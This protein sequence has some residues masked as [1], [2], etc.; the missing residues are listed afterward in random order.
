MKSR[1]LLAL[2]LVAGL[3]RVLPAQV[4]V[5][6]DAFT[7]SAL[8]NANYGVSL[9]LV[10]QSPTAT[11]TMV[12]PAEFSGF[13]ANTYLKFDLAA[14]PS[15]AVPGN[16]AKANLRLYVDFVVSPGT[17]DVYQAAGPWN[18]A[19]LTAGNA[20]GIVG[21][22]I[23]QS[24][25]LVT[26][27]LKYIDIDIT[28]AFANSPPANGFVLVPSKGSNIFASFDSKENPLTSH[29][30]DLTVSV[31]DASSVQLQQEIKRAT[32]AENT[33][34]TNLAT[35]TTRAMGVENTLTN[36]LSAEITRAK[37]AEASLSATTSA[38]TSRAQGAEAGLTTSLNNEVA[39]RVA[40]DQK[41]LAAATAYTDMS[42]ANEA[43]QR[44]NADNALQGNITA[45]QNSLSSY[46]QLAAANTFQASQ[47]I[48]GDL[49]VNNV[50][51]SGL[52]TAY[53]ALLPPLQQATPA[54]GFPSNPFDITAS[55]SDGTN[56]H[57]E[58]FRWQA[59]PVNNG[60]SN[61]TAQLSLLYGGGATPAAT[62]FSI[63]ADGTQNFVANQTF[64]GTHTGDGS[65][66][67]F[68]HAI[69][70]DN[71]TTAGT[72]T[73]AATAVTATTAVSAS[74]AANFTGILAGDVTGAQSSTSVAALAGIPLAKTPPQDGQV[75]TYSASANQWQP[76]AQSGVNAPV[77]A[78]P[79]PPAN[80]GTYML[81]IN[82]ETIPLE[83]FAG[84]DERILGVLYNECYLQTK[85]LTPALQQWI[86]DAI[87]GNPRTLSRD[88]TILGGDSLRKV[89]GIMQVHRAF[90]SDLAFSDF[91]ASSAAIGSLSLVIVPSTVDFFS[92]DGTQDLPP[93]NPAAVPWTQRDFRFAVPSTNTTGIRAVQGIHMSIPK[94][95]ASSL[96]TRLQFQPGAPAFSDILISFENSG[97]TA[98][99]LQDWSNHIAHG[100]TDQRSGQLEIS[101]SLNVIA[102][103]QF[104]TLTPTSIASFPVGFF[105][106]L[107]FSVGSFTLQ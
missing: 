107:D 25:I 106:T 75:L 64:N 78:V 21:S 87:A 85:E 30:P 6:D 91:D 55:L 68:V 29:D 103:L 31:N 37:S 94:M 43:T 45:L 65:G 38:E 28:S 99:D 72:A 53:G 58:T 82:G 96:G 17:F 32:Q 10:V 27:A 51:A 50:N 36:S 80:S 84:C 23:N 59:V 71:A 40:G 26:T 19:T 81:Q 86:H 92:Q 11:G 77:A 35:E 56:S 90:I 61:L 62:G 60:T 102:T 73:T 44:G 4:A 70:A 14:L 9:G 100:L 54:Q 8:P 24:P 3:I 89:I 101:V 49:A 88:I 18:E 39:N 1:F 15:N 79:P 74:T 13:T 67:T 69:T 2:L 7:S 63:N 95:P 104:T 41:A 52:L 66:L 42:V 22:P 20:P 46:A 97:A 5:S 16:I 47:T 93:A 57:N 33:I 12:S 34:S 105:R 83:S 48:S 98:S 76:A